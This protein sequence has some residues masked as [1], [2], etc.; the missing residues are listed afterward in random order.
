MATIRYCIFDDRPVKSM[1]EAKKEWGRAESESGFVHESDG[2]NC[3]RRVL[4]EEQ[5]YTEGESDLN[6]PARSEL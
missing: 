1:T 2:A 3:G 4:R 5:T 6:A